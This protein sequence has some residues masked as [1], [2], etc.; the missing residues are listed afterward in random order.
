MSVPSY[1]DVEPDWLDMMAQ[2]ED[3]D[4]A[5]SGIVGDDTAK[6]LAALVLRL[7]RKLEH[8]DA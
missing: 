6:V 8:V 7:L 2:A 5:I 3:L 1:D 4:D